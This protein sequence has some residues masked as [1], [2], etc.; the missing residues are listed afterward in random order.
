MPCLTMTITAI[1]A[2]VAVGLA[3]LGLVKPQWPAVAVA[4]LLLAVA[5]LIQHWR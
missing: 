2:L 1:L 4:V 5:F 3:I